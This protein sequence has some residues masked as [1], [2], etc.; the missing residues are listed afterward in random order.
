MSVTKLQSIVHN[1]NRIPRPD[2]ELTSKQ[3]LENL[4][5]TKL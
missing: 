2:E 3:I 1:N 4:E 5:R